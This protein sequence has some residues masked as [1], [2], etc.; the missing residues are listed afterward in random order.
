M[1]TFIDEVISDFLSRHSQNLVN[2]VVILPSKRAGAFFTKKLRL[3]LEGQFTFL[4]KTLSIEELIEDISGLTA[5]SSTQLQVELYQ[6]YLRECPE[7]EPENFLSFLGWA[8]TLIGDFNEID[9]H[10]IPQESFFDYL[11]AVKEL[12]QWST[13]QPTELISNYLKFWRSVK[14]Y[15]SAFTKHLIEKGIAYQGMLYRESVSRIESYLNNDQNNYIFCGF[16]A[17]NRA[18]Q[19]LIRTFLQRKGTHIYWDLDPYF[20]T[21]QNHI[22]HTFISKY[23]EEWS[24]LKANSTLL[25]EAQSNFNT[26][27]TIKS[28]GIAQNI[29]QIKYVGQILESFSP[30]DI[31][32]TAVVLGDESLLLPLLN[33]LPPG[34]KT[35]N[36]TMG[37][38]LDQISQAAFFETWFQLQINKRDSEYYYKDV[39]AL[40]DQPYAIAL[41]GGSRNLLKAKITSKN[42]IYLKPQEL[43]AHNQAVNLLFEDW[44]D[45]SQAAITASLNL[46]D[47]LKAIM[48]AEQ[49]WIEL[50]FLA[51]FERLF[52]QLGDLNASYPYFNT[53]KTLRQFYRDLLQKET[54]DFKGDPYQGLQIMGVLESRVIDF[55]HVIITSLNEGT[56]P[57]GKSQNSF[58]PFD[59]KIEY[60]LPTYREKDAIYAYHFFRLLQRAETAHLLFNNEASGLNSGEKSRFL[61][62]LA[63]DSEALYHYS[64]STAS[65]SVKIEPPKLKAVSKTP[66]LIESLK[67]H[68]RSGFSPSALTTYIRNPI[69]FY[70]KYVLG[71]Q[72]LEEVEDTIAHNTLGTVVHESLEQ[73]YKP[74]LNEVLSPAI[75]QNLLKQCDAEV[76][77]QFELCYNIGNIKTGKNLIIFNVAK[78][79]VRNFLQAELAQLEAGSEI[80]ITGLEL[81]F[82]TQIRPD[83]K[84]KGTVDRMDRVDGTLRILDYKTGRVEAGE[85]VIKDWETLITDYKKQSKAFQVLCY[86]LML[87]K[88]KSLPEQAEA[89]IISFKNL[90]RGF[91]K[92]SESKETSITPEL[93]ETFEVYLNRLIDEIL[94]INTPFIEKEV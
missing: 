30:D 90:G 79:F 70:Y 26:P 91:L 2:T 3:H 41:L 34:V 32:D 23:L 16:N 54:L 81:K 55:K 27:K 83:L 6:V 58:I 21:G 1:T 37:L 7:D 33:S 43:V 89:G 28:I 49:K 25:P 12:N 42:L 61:L 22:A 18:E 15:Y 20:R 68:A 56:L 39:L 87:S 38:S 78:Q 71:I 29:G 46:I 31:N 19:Q 52:N 66:E 45:A 47:Q 86:A 40:L 35:V 85:L 48:Q 65:A 94:D 50:E 67:K 14:T 74:Y 64:E 44:K 62:Q 36:V 69:D 84:L 17:L 53:V 8:Q 59:L 10:L 13:E 73:L 80:L 72:E 60:N 57:S 92:L 76:S 93:L 82:E 75:L 11:S 88:E 51:A 24:E 63:T 77:R 9:R 4:P 5:A